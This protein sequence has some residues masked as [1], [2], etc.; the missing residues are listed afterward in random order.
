MLSTSVAITFTMMLLCV[1]TEWLPVVCQSE[2]DAL[3]SFS[4][5]PLG[6]TTQC[7]ADAEAAPLRE[8][9]DKHSAL[10]GAGISLPTC[11]LPPEALKDIDRATGFSPLIVCTIV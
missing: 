1:V 5:S 2:S 9:A 6:N 7:F 11:W 3:F 10:I 4:E 8:W